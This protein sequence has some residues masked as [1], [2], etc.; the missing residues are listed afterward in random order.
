[1]FAVFV[2]LV[3]DINEFNKER[4]FQTVNWKPLRVG[5]RHFQHLL[6][7]LSVFKEGSFET[8]KQRV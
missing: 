4:P 2:F 8:L 1:M 7:G 5:Q 3:D 6:L